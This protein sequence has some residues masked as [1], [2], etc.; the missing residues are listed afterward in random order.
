MERMAEELH[1]QE[2]AIESRQADLQAAQSQLWSKAS[3]RNLLF[4]VTF[5]L[6]G[7]HTSIQIS[8]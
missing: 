7:F 3:W 6:K 8:I 2:D 1:G 4:A 5:I